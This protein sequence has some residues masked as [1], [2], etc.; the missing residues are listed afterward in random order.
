VAERAVSELES[1]LSECFAELVEYRGEFSGGHVRRAGEYVRLIGAELIAKGYFRRDLTAEDLE[2]M[3]K[4][5]PLHDVGKIA[6]SDRYLLKPDRLD[7]VEFAIMKNHA[8]IGAEIL[9]NMYRR[10][11]TQTYLTYAKM[12]AASHHERY[13]GRGYP[14]R[15]SRED[16]P[17]CGRIMAVADVY[18]ALVCDRA[19]RKGLSHFEARGIILEGKGTQF[20]PAVVEAFESCHEKIAAV[21]GSAS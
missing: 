14:S 4:A 20:D 16:I 1:A 10:M 9:G 17:L 19:Y 8:A 21:A 15:L 18:D 5:A 2:L 13:D 6:I 3:A 12:I 11:P 7:D